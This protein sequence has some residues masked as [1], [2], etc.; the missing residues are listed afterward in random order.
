[1]YQGHRHRHKHGHNNADVH[2]RIHSVQRIMQPVVPK[3]NKCTSL[4]LGY[5]CIKIKGVIFARS[6]LW[7]PWGLH[8]CAPTNV[9]L[10]NISLG[11]TAKYPQE[12]TLKGKQHMGPYSGLLPCLTL[13][14][15]WTSTKIV[16]M[17]H[18]KEDIP[19]ETRWLKGSSMENSI[20]WYFLGLFLNPHSTGLPL[21]FTG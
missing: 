1:M 10:A 21:L 16:A 12:S 7:K 17:N 2:R 15:H 19:S 6:N 20:S 8:N 3:R 13:T 11:L 14:F 9:H 4:K 18:S 5:E